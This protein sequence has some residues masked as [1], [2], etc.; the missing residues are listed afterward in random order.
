MASKQT[1]KHFLNASRAN[2]P[3]GLSAMPD[4]SSQLPFRW[5]GGHVALDFTNTIAW[6]WLEDGRPAATLPPYERLTSYERLVDWSRNAGLLD[7]RTATALLELAAR[8]PSQAERVLERATTVRGSIHWLF[9]AHARQE[10]IPHEALAVLDA[11]YR[12]GGSRHSIVGTSNGYSLTWM[13]LDVMLDAPL[14]PVSFA[15]VELLTSEAIARVRP[16]AA[17]PCGFLFLDTSQGNRRRWCDMAEC[18]NR[19]KVHRHRVRERS[20][21]RAVG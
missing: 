17:N 10:S 8:S 15:A 9:A 6:T 14:W 2:A 19:A 5:L 4:P 20:R 18:G 7:S 3:R 13:G 11:V 16:C 12:E 21:G 1:D